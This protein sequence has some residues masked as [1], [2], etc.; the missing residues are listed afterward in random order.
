MTET[1]EYKAMTTLIA[2]V[3]NGR[4]ELPP[5]PEFAE[6]TNV[7][8][9]IEPAEESMSVGG[10]PLGYSSDEEYGTDPESIARWIADFEAMEPLDI[11][12][13]E[14]EAIRKDRQEYRAWCLA[15]AERREARKRTDLQ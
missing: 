11:S 2:K 13:A 15:D 5:M 7:S 12:D 10:K 8:V 4:I 1:R 3:R 14:W 9:T 6:G